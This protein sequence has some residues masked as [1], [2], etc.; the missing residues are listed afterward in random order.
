MFFCVVP[1]YA[2]EIEK[3]FEKKFSVKEDDRLEI[4]NKYGFVRIKTWEQP[5]VQITA[6][7]IV[8]A[9]SERRAQQ[10]LD[11]IQIELQQSGSTVSGQTHIESEG[12][13]GWGN[14]LMYKINYTVLM[15]DYLFLDVEN[16][17]GN[18]QIATLDR[19]IGVELKY[20][21]LSLDNQGHKVD[22]ELG[23]GNGTWNSLVDLDAEMKYSTVSCKKIRKGNIESKNCNITIEEADQLE[24]ESSY[25]TYNINTIKYL[26]ND[27]KYDNFSI[28]RIGQLKVETKY[29]EYELEKVFESMEIDAKYTDIEV[30]EVDEAAKFVHL[31][32]DY[33]EIYIYT[34]DIGYNL[35]LD[36]DYMDFSLH[37]GLEIERRNSS[38]HSVDL[39]GIYKQ[40]GVDI[41]IYGNYS[42]C[43]IR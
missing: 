1:S 34:G 12:S 18:I 43:K 24:I 5:F 10:T 27:G 37:K 36:G 33:M 16:K 40:G 20:G 17:Y 13:W 7:V 31:E 19:P 28:G 9:S 38:R 11:R 35:E 26:E 2:A 32:G 3:V 23:Y 30:N 6:Q 21:D 42:D 39:K 15:P 41:G 8:K 14:N 22:V 4:E 25:D 29:A